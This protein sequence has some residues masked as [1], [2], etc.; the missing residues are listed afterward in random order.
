MR[1]SI[2][3]EKS[4]IVNLAIAWARHV[5][6]VLKQLQVCHKMHSFDFYNKSTAK[7]RNNKFP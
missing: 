2:G 5:I 1:L 6:I 3:G 7:N 4:N